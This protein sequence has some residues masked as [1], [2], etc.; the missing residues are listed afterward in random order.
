MFISLF[1]I[2]FISYKLCSNFFRKIRNRIPHNLDINLCTAIRTNNIEIVRKILVK[3]PEI[4]KCDRQCSS[5]LMKQRSYS[6]WAVI[7]YASEAIFELLIDLRIIE[8]NK[9]LTIV[10]AN[11]EVIEITLLHLLAIPQEK[12]SREKVA[13]MLIKRG[14][15]VN[16][17]PPSISM[18]P[19]QYAIVEG[20]MQYAKLLLKN[21]A[22]LTGPEWN[23]RNFPMYMVALSPANKQIEILQLLIEYGLDTRFCNNEGENYLLFALNRAEIFGNNIVAITDILLN[24]GI[25]VNDVNNFGKSPLIYAVMIKNIQLISTLIKRGADVNYQVNG[26][27]FPLLYAT[28]CNEEN[29]VDLLLS[30]GAEV[31]AKNRSGATALHAACLG[32]QEKIIKVLLQKGASINEMDEKGHT[33]FF[34]LISQKSYD[35]YVPCI[36]TVTKEMAKQKFL[37][38]AELSEK[39]MALITA[40]SEIQTLFLNCMEELY[41]L[42]SIKFYARYS[43]HSVWNMSRNL[44]KLANLTKN[45]EFVFK[46]EQGLHKF[47][48]YKDDLRRI[49]D[50][51]IQVRDKS[52]TVISRLKDLF[53][54]LLP[55]IVIRKLSENLIPEDL[56]LESKS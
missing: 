9:R 40:N 48:D 18:T 53:K 3:H 16:A 23:D 28:L 5:N 39:N 46:F 34:Y 4:I 32:C 41:Q 2:I 51:A 36:R 29:I 7:N 21:G 25:P 55:E 15:D 38:N 13:E 22:R 10:T 45:K 24:S 12:Q 14:A 20:H 37:K 19:L 49:F 27:F 26:G 47:S 8:I 31:N 33:P 44:K 30:S 1:S 6:F 17:C 56:P 52:I 50:D 54:D 35:F 42:S 11:N 43:Y